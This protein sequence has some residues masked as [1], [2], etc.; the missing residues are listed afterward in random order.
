MVDVENS[1]ENREGDT[2]HICDREKIVTSMRAMIVKT[3]SD[4]SWIIF[5]IVSEELLETKI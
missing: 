1:T 5:M 3:K 4:S 2:D